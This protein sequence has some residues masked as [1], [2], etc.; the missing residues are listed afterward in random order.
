MADSAVV[1][2]CRGPKLP[3]LIKVALLC[4]MSSHELVEEHRTGYR[5]TTLHET[6]LGI[7]PENSSLQ[8]HL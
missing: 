3:A 5:L 1:E 6:L 4:N 8:E 2:K 7:N